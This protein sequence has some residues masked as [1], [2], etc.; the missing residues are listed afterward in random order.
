[1]KKPGLLLCSI[2]SV[3]VLGSCQM[4]EPV[5]ATLNMDS[6]LFV[7]VPLI[8]P[9][10]IPNEPDDGWHFKPVV[11][12][13]Q[14][15]ALAKAGKTQLP[16]SW[17]LVYHD[18]D[19][20][21]NAMSSWFSQLRGRMK[22][23]KYMADIAQATFD[24]FHVYPQVVEPNLIFKP[25][26]NERNDSSQCEESCDKLVVDVQ[27]DRAWPHHGDPNW[28]VKMTRMD[29]ARAEVEKSG[30]HHRI[31]IGFLDN[32]FQGNHAAFPTHGTAYRSPRVLADSIGQLGC[33]LDGCGAVDPTTV[34]SQGHGTG[35][36]GSLAGRPM[37]FDA[38]GK[39]WTFSG[40]VPDAQV[41]PIRISPWVA[42][43]ATANM[44]YGIDHASRVEG[45]DVISMSHGGAPSLMW[46]DA[47][48]SAYDRGTV[49]VAAAANYFNLAPF[50]RGV[51][52]PSTT[53]YPAACRRVLGVSGVTASGKS[54]GLTDWRT[55]G[56]RIIDPRNWLLMR[57]SAGPDGSYFSPNPF[58][59]SGGSIDEKQK[60]KLGEL[61]CHQISAPT[62]NVPWLKAPNSKTKVRNSLDLDGGGTS[63][64]TPQVAGAAALWLAKN[65]SKIRSAGKW[66]SWEKAESTIHALLLSA[67]RQ[68]G[69][70][71]ANPRPDVRKRIGAGVLDARAA[72]DHDFDS[73]R[74]RTSS[75]L[76]LRFPTDPDGAPLD[77]YDGTL[78][79]TNI[80]IPSE[81]RHAGNHAA[82]LD[83]HQQFTQ[84]EEVQ[85]ALETLFYNES[86]LFRWRNGAL[87]LNDKGLSDMRNPINWLL[88]PASTLR[89]MFFLRH[90]PELRAQAARDAQKALSK[91]DPAQK[92]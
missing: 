19:L 86:M 91:K 81:R 90:E 1:M 38:F 26:K 65:E 9:K 3:F 53:V 64:A 8:K 20:N 67:Q 2:T 45:C 15:A 7:R 54:Y 23:R 11:Q 73:I 63:S 30:G 58:D 52:I 48:N 16:G 87:P 55:L 47:V 14:A 75:D 44:A 71:P 49:I 10:A 57:G 88:H 69:G 74:R 36:I 92:P 68:G 35:T 34:G 50:N 78:S 21:R 79:V 24:R 43:F 82:T 28:H 83:L 51:I 18:R 89:R 40:A 4:L 85:T 76:S 56:W 32:G 60:C 25:Q 5:T 39:S 33:A 46:M 72:L 41:V 84:P 59:E 13:S 66:N 12:G 62:P 17:Y 6:A 80:L 37:K 29:E 61:H 31:R 42:S 77:T 70:D 27:P 22:A